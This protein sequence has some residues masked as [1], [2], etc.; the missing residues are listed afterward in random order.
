[1]LNYKQTETPCYSL[2]QPHDVYDVLSY[3]I[4]ETKKKVIRTVHNNNFAH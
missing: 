2:L 1:M 4:V 3:I